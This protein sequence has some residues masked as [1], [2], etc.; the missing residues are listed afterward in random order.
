MD[1]DRQA[2]LFGGPVDGPVLPPPEREFLH[3][4]QQH[5]D[6][7]AIGGATLD[8][9]GGAFRPMAGDDDGG[10]QA[11]FVVEEF[12]PHPVVDGAAEGGGEILAI[13]R[14]GAMDHV[15]DGEAGAERIERLGAD[16]REG[17]GRLAAL[18]LAGPPVRP[19]RQRRVQRVVVGVEIVPIEAAHF[20]DFPPVGVEMRHQHA[21]G[22][23]VEVDVAVDRATR[24]VQGRASGA[25]G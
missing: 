14:L 24:G 19:G 17:A 12:G 15:A 5:A 1:V 18:C 20:D 25:G 9:L 10:A 23:Q 22:G 13:H 4:E 11:R 7:A 16:L 6:E 2:M 21:C 8:F 3:R